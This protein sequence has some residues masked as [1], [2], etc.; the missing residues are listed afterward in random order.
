MAY[1]FMAKFEI[2]RKKVRTSITLDPE[3]FK[4]VESKIKEHEFASITHAVEKALY[5][6]KEKM[7]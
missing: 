4:W 2:D 5:L 6:L 7:G 1:C 3:L